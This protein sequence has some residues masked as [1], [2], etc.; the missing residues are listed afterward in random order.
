MNL[1]K[2]LKFLRDENARRREIVRRA[3]DVIPA[4]H[5][6][7]ERLREQRRRARSRLLDE[8]TPDRLCP[9]C[10][11]HITNDRRWVVMRR[12]AVCRSCHVTRNVTRN[13]RR[14]TS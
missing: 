5:S 13:M 10:R 9:V 8:L 6:H 7:A 3:C 1:Y 4:Y 14:K 2:V 12:R 11:R